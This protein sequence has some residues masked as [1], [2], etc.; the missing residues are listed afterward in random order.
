MARNPLGNKNSRGGAGF[1][2]YRP[3]L[4]YRA[5]V[6]AAATG[7]LD[8]NL[9]PLQPNRSCLAGSQN[10]AIQ[11]TGPKMGCLYQKVAMYQKKGVTLCSQ[12]WQKKKGEKKR[13][14]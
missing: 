7:Y 11:K 13:I 8:R 1:L 2:G 4:Y 5:W 6:G 3:S 12:K 14:A 10:R 9:E